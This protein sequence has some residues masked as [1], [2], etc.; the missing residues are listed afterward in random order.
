MSASTISIQ[1][2]LFARLTNC[3]CCRCYDKFIV[4]DLCDLAAA[5]SNFRAA[6]RN[7]FLTCAI[8]SR[9]LPF[10]ARHFSSEE[11]V[12][13]ETGSTETMAPSAQLMLFLELTSF[14]DLYGVTPLT[15]LRDIASRIA[16]KFFLPTNVDN[17]LQPPLFDFHHIVA[18]SSLRHLEF[19]LGGN[20]RSIPRDIFLDF[21]KAVVDSLTGAPFLSFLASSECSRMRGYL[22]DTSPYVNLPLQTLFGALAGNEIHSGAKN[23]FAFVLVFLICQL[24]REQTGEHDF[25]EGENNRLLG[26]ASGV[27]CVVYIRRTLLPA[28]ECATKSRSGDSLRKVIQ[29][30][31]TIWDQY[32][33]PSAGSL[34]AFTKSIETESA[35]NAVRDLLVKAGDAAKPHC[36]DALETV[37]PVVDALLDPKLT[38]EAR[39]LADELLY[40][41]AVNV[42]TKFR[43]HKCHEWMCSE[44]CKMRAGDPTWT[45]TGE[46]PMLP[47]GCVKRLLRKTEFPVG[48]SPHK[49]SYRPPSDAKDERKSPDE[50]HV[51]ADYAVVFGTAVGDDLMAQMPIPGIEHS[52]IRRYA[53]LPVNLD[54]NQEHD[55]FSEDPIPPTFESYAIGP[56]RKPKPFSKIA[57]DMRFR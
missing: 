43:E 49:P 1:I 33:A 39:R 14:I 13:G 30:W 11:N 8:D 29:A 4:T 38:N 40:D 21:Q 19:V 15:R 54:R 42:H 55:A 35:L 25:S 5:D 16:H 46:L 23:S 36:I 20:S 6:A 9:R 17:R 7:A 41:Y 22:R 53:C 48:V 24:E 52:D 3:T 2:V 37:A 50:R 44:L 34:D 26:A 47:Q 27:C 45:N 10:L 28:V 18:D 31:E 51:N 32:V 56:R 57:D 12:T